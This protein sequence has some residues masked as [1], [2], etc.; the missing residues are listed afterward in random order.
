MLQQQLPAGP[1]PM[2]S[3]PPHLTKLARWAALTLLAWM[4]LLLAA[5]CGDDSSGG[6]PGPNSPSPEAGACVAPGGPCFND[7]E[8][9][10]RVCDLGEC[11]CASQSERCAADG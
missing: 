10:N 2:T 8:C 5:S 11:A 6:E 3:R 9:C 4:G 7:A 1:M